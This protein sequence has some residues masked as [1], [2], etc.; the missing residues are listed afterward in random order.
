MYDGA[1]AFA[2]AVILAC[3]VTNRDEA[4]LVGVHPSWA[5]VT[6]TYVEGLGIRVVEAPTPNGVGDRAWLTDRVGSGTAVVA[7][8]QPNFYGSVEELRAL[9]DLAHDAGALLVVGANPIALGL[10]ETPGAL[11]ADVVVGEGQPLGLGMNFGGP[12]VGFFAARQKFLR[13]MPGRLVSLTKDREGR[14]GYVLT[15]QTREQHIRRERA[16]S[17]IC[18]NQGLMMLAATVYLSTL[19]KQGLRDVAEQCLQKAHYA[20]ERLSAVP[21]YRLRFQAPFFHEFTLQCPEP[22]VDV[23]NRLAAKGITAGYPLTGE[24]ADCLL[25]AVTEKR[26]RQEIDRFAA[27]LAR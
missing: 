11:G 6:R 10:L 16:T 25:V 27:E 17:N 20:A 21:G 5:D 12:L 15:L 2:E 22:A 14:D 23:A 19:G 4:V 8:Q 26:T 9:A 3:G 24:L 1:T 13:Q 7:V 18:T